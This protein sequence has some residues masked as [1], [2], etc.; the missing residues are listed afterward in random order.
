MTASK[1]DFG[2]KHAGSVAIDV[3]GG[4]ETKSSGASQISDTDLAAAIK[5]SIEKSGVFEKVLGASAA[6][7]KLDVGIVRVQQPIAGFNMT[8][9]LEVNW[10][11]TRRSDGSVV[12][13]RAEVSTYTATMGDAF[14]GVARLRMATEG[15]ARLNIEQAL[16]EIGKLDIR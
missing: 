9:N 7:Y 14:A 12:W 13:Q 8:V 5:A 1:T 3:T 16:G 10:T 6:D 2:R 15:A 4:S 11:L